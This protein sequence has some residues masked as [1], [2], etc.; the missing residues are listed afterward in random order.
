MTPRA[1]AR[2]DARERALRAL[3]AAYDGEYFGRALLDEWQQ[4]QPL[5]D[6]DAGLALEL[7]MGVS[8]VRIT[9][10]H[11]A[12][13]FYR[14][15][16][17]GLRPSIRVVVALGIY[18]LCWLERIPDHAAVDQSVRMA[19][20]YGR[21]TADMV[22][23]LL[24]KVAECRGPMIAKPAEPNP[25]QYLAVEPAQG[26][27][28]NENIFPD[29]ARRPL[30]YLV[31]ATGHPAWLVERWHRRFKPQRCRQ[32]CEADQFRPPLVLRPNGLRTTTDALL[33][34]LE[35]DGLAPRIIEGTTAILLPD[36]PSAAVMAVVGEGLCQPQDS[37]SQIALN[38]S[39]PKPGEFVLDLCAGVGTKSTQA[40]EWMKNE[41]IVLATDLDD[42]KLTK[43][44]G[45]AER[46]GL[47]IVQTTPL[48]ALDF[49]LIKI[50]RQ[51][52][53]ILVDAPCTNSGVLARRPEARYRAGQKALTSLMMTQIEILDR[54]AALSGPHTRI[55]YT[56]CSLEK[57]ENEDQARAFIERHAGWRIAQESFTLPDLE[58]GGGY[59]AVLVHT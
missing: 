25:R 20:R 45:G 55:V 18:Q 8:R 38:L 59:A 50:G 24:R 47:S 10:E 22:N 52:D 4:A 26:R 43:V 54:A 11:I 32:I 36:G 16:W 3:V 13:H 44:L 46:L 58:R 53:A 42:G 35:S 14:G 19:K 1:P 2:S 6:A 56:T 7:V 27:M 23:A 12:S 17:A 28:F 9:A 48:D 49:A 40:A 29:P 51:P 31:A 39:P 33:R 37:T 5:S 41:G 30:D 21:G 15:R 34:R 57:E